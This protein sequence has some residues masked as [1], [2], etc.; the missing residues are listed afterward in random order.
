M[1]YITEMIDKEFTRLDYQGAG[2]VLTDARIT[3]EK[4]LNVCL[5]A[6][7]TLIINDKNLE[8]ALESNLLQT[9]VKL[10]R[11]LPL[12]GPSMTNQVKGFFKFA[13]RCLTSAIR[14]E[15]SVI[16]VSATH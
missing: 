2:S 11:G 7:E 13:L 6:L 12:R 3:T 4:K 8:L 5:V 10:I 1:I 16:R 9:I 15:P 14:T